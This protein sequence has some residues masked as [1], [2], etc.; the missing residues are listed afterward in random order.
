MSKDI[1]KAGSLRG[2]TIQDLREELKQTEKDLFAI[3]FR[4]LEGEKP[5]VTRPRKVRKNIAKYNTM[6][7]EL[8]LGI[9]SGKAQSRPKLSR[10]ARTR[11][12]GRS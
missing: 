4:G 6:I 11:Q 7:R 12:Q 10:K 8:E 5:D 1:I 3:Q 9:D 2:R